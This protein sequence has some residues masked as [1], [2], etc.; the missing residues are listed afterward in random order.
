V[1]HCVGRILA[2]FWSISPLLLV[3][4]SSDSGL[5]RRKGRDCTEVVLY[6]RDAKKVVVL[7]V[8]ETGKIVVSCCCHFLASFWSISPLL[9]VKASSDSGLNRRKR[10]DCTEVVLYLRIAEHSEEHHQR[11]KT[12]RPISVVVAKAQYPIY[13]SETYIDV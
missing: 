13:W 6:P 2:I 8:I 3:K 4:A 12:A 1:W 9:L 10:R 11:V 5:N 7:G